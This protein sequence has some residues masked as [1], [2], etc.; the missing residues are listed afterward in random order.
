VRELSFFPSKNLSYLEISGNKPIS[1]FGLVSYCSSDLRKNLDD[2]FGE[3]MRGQIQEGGFNRFFWD[4]V[5]DM[6]PLKLPEYAAQ[7]TS[8][9]PEQQTLFQAA[10]ENYELKRR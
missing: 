7:T 4:F 5:I 2:N 3:V 6:S 1:P 8:D 9:S 10:Q